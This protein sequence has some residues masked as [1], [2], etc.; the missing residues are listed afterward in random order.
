[1]YGGMENKT[2]SSDQPSGAPPPVISP[3]AVDS[4]CDD[5]IV[6]VLKH[7]PK[8]ASLACAARAMKRWRRGGLSP[9]ILRRFRVHHHGK[10]SSAT[11][12]WP[13]QAHAWCSNQRSM[14][15][16]TPI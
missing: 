1:M 7:L 13:N 6:E 2:S 15:S 12:T 16:S 14:S 3:I 4:L 9:A 10:P 11:T 8:I 5:V